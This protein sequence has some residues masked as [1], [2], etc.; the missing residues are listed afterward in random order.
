MNTYQDNSCRVR[1]LSR[2][3]N[4]SSAGCALFGAET[5]VSW[6]FWT[7]HSFF[8][9]HFS[10]SPT[11]HW[12]YG[13]CPPLCSALAILYAFY[14]ALLRFEHEIS[15]IASC[16]WPLPWSPTCRTI[17]GGLE[18]SLLAPVAFRFVVFKLPCK[19]PAP[20]SRSP[21]FPH[22][23]G[24]LLLKSWVKI[25]SLLKSCFWRWVCYMLWKV[26]NKGSICRHKCQ[27]PLPR[28][29]SEGSCWPSAPEH[30][31]VVRTGRNEH[32]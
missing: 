23:G 7:S 9:L 20:P 27:C 10:H 12:Q 17:W 16:A 26:T 8:L 32:R 5:S 29:S 31:P 2:L 14:K 19:L 3:Q 30:V 13:G 18:L 1:L 11:A 4:S 25:T 28:P 24:L 15:P 6:A 22:K 21:R